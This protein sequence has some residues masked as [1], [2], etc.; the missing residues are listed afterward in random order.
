ME[1]RGGNFS[2]TLILTVSS[3]GGWNLTRD[4]TSALFSVAGERFFPV[5]WVVALGR[6]GLY[7]RGSEALPER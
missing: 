1:E 3:V 5:P 6:G 4:P 7:P 2:S